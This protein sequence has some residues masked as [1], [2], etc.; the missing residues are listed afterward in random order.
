MSRCEAVHGRGGGVANGCERRSRW[1]H[2]R[3]LRFTSG[4]SARL[5]TTRWNASRPCFA[6]PNPRREVG[7]RF[8][9]VDWP[10]IG[11]SRWRRRRKLPYGIEPVAV[12]PPRATR[13]AR[14]RARPREAPPATRRGGS[15]SGARSV[16][17]PRGIRENSRAARC[18]GA[19][20]RTEA[21]VP[22]RAPPRLRFSSANCGDRRQPPDRR[23][24]MRRPSEDVAGRRGS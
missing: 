22:Y 8:S 9:E 18:I 21:G 4:A 15:A 10:H 5:V 20:A 23:T 12:V 24:V 13:D 16:R 19:R 17:H 6:T 2:T 7:A 3:C 1:G 14:G 11:A